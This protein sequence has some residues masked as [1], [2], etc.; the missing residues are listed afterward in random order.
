MRTSELERVID[1]TGAKLIY[2][3]PTFQNPKGTTLSLERRL[4]LT[5][6]A[7]EKNVAVLEDEP[8]TE[9]RYAGAQLP[10][11]AALDGEAPVIHLGTFSKTLA[12]GLRIAWAVAAPDTIHALTVAK[13]AADLHTNTLTQRAVARMLETFDYDGHLAEIRV[14]YGER[15]RAMR[16]AVLASFPRGTRCTDPAGG[17]FLWASIPGVDADELLFDALRERV[18]FVPGAPFFARTPDRSA[19]RLNFSNRPSE[20]IAE[21]V[22]RLGKAA[23]KRLAGAEPA[24]QIATSA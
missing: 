15:C 22:A 24:A 1:Q 6:I 8:Y 16:A 17:L 14:L 10:S 4:E 11:L 19:L 12:P 18:A 7:R 13:Q 3:T 9:L 20:L 2:V 23:A 5:R 21:G